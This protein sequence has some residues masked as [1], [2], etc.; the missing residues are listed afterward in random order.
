M[1]LIQ[2]KALIPSEIA[3]EYN[4]GVVNTHDVCIKEA[5][6]ELLLY[7]TT[8]IYGLRKSWNVSFSSFKKVRISF[9]APMNFIDEQNNSI[10]K[11][12]VVPQ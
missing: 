10:K 11:P 2:Q 12:F 8:M 9:I 1:N 7:W 4:E 5:K 6:G 3:L